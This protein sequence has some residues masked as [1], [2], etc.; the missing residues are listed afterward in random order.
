MGLGMCVSTLAYGQGSDYTLCRIEP[1]DKPEEWPSRCYHESAPGAGSDT[2]YGGSG[3]VLNVTRKVGDRVI[4]S[5]PA[6]NCR[7]REDRLFGTTAIVVDSSKSLVTTDPENDRLSAGT[8][9]IDSLADRAANTNLPE[10]DPNFPKLGLLSYGGRQG[11]AEGYETD[12]L[13][14]K[15][16]EAF[17]LN[18]DGALGLDKKALVKFDSPE[19]RERW[20]RKDSAGNLISVCESLSPV[21]LTKLTGA[22][23][24]DPSVTRL[25]EFLTFTGQNPRGS[26]DLLYF[27]E[28][29]TQAGMLGNLSNIARNA[30]VITDGL[31][32][33]PKYV[34][35]EECKKKPYLKNEP[36]VV[37][38][39][40]GGFS[41]KVCIYRQAQKAIDSVNGYVEGNL[42]F[43]AGKNEN[44]SSGK[45]FAT[46]NSYNILFAPDNQVYY[47]LD[48]NGQINP[49]DFLIENSARSGNGKV[50]FKWAKTKKELVDYV[51]DVIV[52]KLDKASLQRV[53]VRV[54][55]G[56]EYNAVSPAD[57]ANS[58]KIFSIKFIG[59]KT[60]ANEVLVDFFYS[61][62]GALPFTRRFVVNV[63]ETG[64]PD[65]PFTCSGQSY[66]RTVDGDDPKSLE[67]KGDGV[68]P[69]P[70]SDGSQDRVFR[71]ADD[72]NSYD[73][74]K[75]RPASGTPGD[76]VTGKPIEKAPVN[77][78]DLRIQGG[79]GNCG[80]LVGKLRGSDKLTS[81]SPTP[82]TRGIAL[83]LLLLPLALSLKIVRRGLK[84]AALLVQTKRGF[85]N[86][87]GLLFFLLASVWGGF[88][89]QA[90]AQGLNSENFSA[91][92][93]NKSS[94]MW[95]TARTIKS[96]SL[97][98]AYTFSYALRPVEFGD[99][100][101]ERMR[102]SDHIQINHLGLGYGLTTWMDLGL[103]V[104]F[105]LYSNPTSPQGYVKGVGASRSWFLLSDPRIRAKFS[106]F[107]G[108]KGEGFYAGFLIGAALP[109]GSQEALLSD[110]SARVFLE[111]PFHYA[112]PLGFEWYLTPGFSRWGAS[113]RLKVE[114][115]FI[116]DDDKVLLRRSES[117]LLNTGLRHWLNG[118]G[119]KGGDLQ[120]EAGIRG[121]FSDQKLT[122]G[123]A[124]SPVEWSGGAALWL[125]SG[126][127]VH[128][129]YGTGLGRGVG[130]PLSRIVAGLRYLNPS[131]EATQVKAKNE[132]ATS[133]SYSDQELDQIFA[134]AQ[135][136]APPSDIA[137]QETMLRL[138]TETEVIDIGTLNFD[139]DSSKLT[140]KALETVQRLHE[141]LL[142]L[143]PESIK[144]DGHT[145]SIGSYAYNLAL[146]KRRADSV[147]KALM[148]LGVNAGVIRT[149][150]FSYKYPIAS[151]GTK[152]G[153]TQNRRIDVALDGKSF[154]KQTYTKEE[155]QVFQRWIS[156]GGKKPTK[157]T[158]S[159]D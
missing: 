116:G 104:P 93:D 21:S 47:D 65:S 57:V 151:N 127:S 10:S 69:K 40:A 27:F 12:N 85:L 144:I 54:N 129:A 122:F 15:L 90:G 35:E 102:V 140:E 84:S 96:G 13:N 78:R 83:L 31:P 121:D 149:E 49:P 11:F 44:I 67:P 120:W 99:G 72:S 79:V 64:E 86:R 105:A 142:R 113:T 156:P 130:A 153:R 14:R 7:Q 63:N 18:G 155:T 147:R 88:L 100:K 34:L 62:S 39:D 77:P 1:Q 101:S 89:G 135:R 73:R 152:Q 46:L 55:G 19:A 94:L 8:S 138:M 146:S 82:A 17:C 76:P 81:E 92:V 37:V 9:L 3:G 5:V 115:N 126:L 59:L 125:S 33:L 53:R 22:S 48:I 26:T 110:G 25:K 42:T 108:K 98:F 91:A 117:L 158:N 23:A 119:T 24:A 56:P 106:F 51:N 137:D 71:N 45:Q 131:E 139:F 133:V 128:G 145:D 41:R 109:F 68:L 157:S 107:P 150:G 36:I 97:L 29:L 70:K 143:N 118:N 124:E 134:E 159:E 61:D 141:Q 154:R 87:S 75:L 58:N 30:I 43:V 148:D 28:G 80:S 50:K 38:K 111:I 136:E 103:N 16:E 112:F 20:S 60:G 66:N 74:S 2:Q 132:T 32:N 52:N 95:E 123:S 4:V 114:G 6:Q